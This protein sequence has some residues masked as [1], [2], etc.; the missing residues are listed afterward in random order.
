MLCTIEF[1]TVLEDQLNIGFEF[2][3]LVVG[4]D[5]KLCLNSHKIHWLLD[6][7]VVGGNIQCY[8]VDGVV[9]VLGVYLML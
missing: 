7:I 4:I 5:L 9:E 1:V 3:D 2:V 8:C 6:D